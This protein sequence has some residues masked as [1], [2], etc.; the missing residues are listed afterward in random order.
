MLSDAE[1]GGFRQLI[2]TALPLVRWEGVQGSCAEENDEAACWRHADS[3][4]SV[5]S[6]SSSS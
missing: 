3:I 6:P 1:T 2:V 5:T 4:L